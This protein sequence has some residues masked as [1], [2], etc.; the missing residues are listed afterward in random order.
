MNKCGDEYDRIEKGKYESLLSVYDSVNPIIR[1][2]D[3]KLTEKLFQ[4]GKLLRVIEA[5]P[6]EIELLR[7]LID[8]AKALNNRNKTLR[9]RCSG[10]RLC[11]PSVRGHRRL[12]CGNHLKTS[13]YFTRIFLPEVM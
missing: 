8:N 3:D 10:D 13:D 2:S 1:E 9:R 4:Q 6:A 7:Q 5:M 11:P 12:M